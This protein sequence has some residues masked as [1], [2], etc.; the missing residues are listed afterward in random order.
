M[1]RKFLKVV[2]FS[3]T[4]KGFTHFLE[5]ELFS[6]YKTQEETLLGLAGDLLMIQCQNTLI[7]KIVT[8]FVRIESCMALIMPRAVKTLI[9]S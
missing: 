1:I 9:I 5:I 3:K 6:Q 8:F 7:L 2:F 4:K